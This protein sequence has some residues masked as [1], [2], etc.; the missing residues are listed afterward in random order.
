MIILYFYR[1]KQILH[2]TFL[3]SSKD[4][5]IFFEAL[6]YPMKPNKDLLLAAQEYNVFTHE[7]D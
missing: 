1:T 6:A 3:A 7:N 2:G 5:E 4:A